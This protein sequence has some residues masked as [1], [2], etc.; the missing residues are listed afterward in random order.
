MKVNLGVRKNMIMIGSLKDLKV[1]INR[2]KGGYFISCSTQIH[3]SGYIEIRG[4][5]SEWWVTTGS[6]VTKRTFSCCPGTSVYT[7]EGKFGTNDLQPKN[8]L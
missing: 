4:V 6:G 8:T 3:D 1:N 7:V 5:T 2:G